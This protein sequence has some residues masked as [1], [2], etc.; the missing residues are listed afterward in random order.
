MLHGHGE[1]LGRYQSL[2]RALVGAGYLVVAAD[3]RGSGRSPG[4][5]G[6]I[7]RWECWRDD[8][9]TILA[10]ARERAQG[11][12]VF[13]FGHGLG[14]LL[15]LDLAAAAP[16]G[17]AGVI[18]SAPALA[19]EGPLPLPPLARL[20]ARLA[21]M[22][23]LEFNL[24]PRRL[25]SHP[26]IVASYGDDPLVHRRMSVR[27]AAEVLAAMA[28]VASRPAAIRIP[29]LLMQGGDDSIASPGAIRQFHDGIR[30]PDRML[31]VY[32]GCRHEVHHDGGRLDF[33][34]DLV[35][36]IGERAAAV[37][38]GA[39]AGATQSSSLR[40]MRSDASA[41]L[42]RIVNPSRSQNRSIDALSPS[43]EPSIT[44]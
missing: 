31:R 33:E 17:M 43:T 35:G 7:E 34:R 8:A 5:R 38:A 9:R 23:T 36:W 11:A 26:D 42:D 30:H 3:L 12:P 25:S 28:R 15:A 40:A 27:L 37:G 4:S 14:G 19:Y 13:L 18:A 24:D 1:H 22:L 21:P 2:H 41:G 10:L 39:S 29:C 20:A 44:R 6:H 16:A 32:A